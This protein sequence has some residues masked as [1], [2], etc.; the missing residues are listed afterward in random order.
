MAEPDRIE[1]LEFQIADEMEESPEFSIE[2]SEEDHQQ[3]EEPEFALFD[4]DDAVSEEID[5]RDTEKNSAD[6][7][8][9]SSPS[10]E[11]DLKPTLLMDDTAKSDKSSYSDDILSQPS[12]TRKA[13]SEQENLEKEAPFNDDG[14]EEESIDIDLESDIEFT[15][16]A[17]ALHMQQAHQLEMSLLERIDDLIQVL[18]KRGRG[19]SPEQLPHKQFATGLHYIKHENNHYLGAKW[20]RKAAMQGHAK[21][22]LYLGMLFLQGNG[23]P[24]S[25]FHAYAWFSLAACQ[26]ISEAR[27]ARKKLERHLTAK[28]INAS[29]K[30]AADLLD[31]IH[32]I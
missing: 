29:L 7:E 2:D 23:V 30:Y 25:F 32:Q 18:E 17:S 15:H 21:A 13:S 19:H 31:K 9:A 28:E 16:S 20:L 22:Q 10:A 4:T 8:V 27:D 11:A 5:R 12:G 14:D 6:S 24:K 3:S 26:D 1:E